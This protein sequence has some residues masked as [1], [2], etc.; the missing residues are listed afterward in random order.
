MIG[1]FDFFDGRSGAHW[2][3]PFINLTCNKFI[4]KS[5]LIIAFTIIY[6]L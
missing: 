5:L 1:Y 3:P 2:S 6:R 4:I